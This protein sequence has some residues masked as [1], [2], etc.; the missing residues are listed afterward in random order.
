[1]KP[2]AVESGYR[3]RVLLKTSAASHK[4]AND[5]LYAVPSG[6]GSAY[7]LNSRARTSRGERIVN[8]ARKE[9]YSAGGA[10]N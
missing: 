7:S 6:S 8:G 10:I 3:E 9:R 4:G 2:P 5:A 1:M